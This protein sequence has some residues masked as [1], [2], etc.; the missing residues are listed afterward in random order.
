VGPQLYYPT[1]TNAALGLLP[2]GSGPSAKFVVEGDVI[3]PAFR[4]AEH[5][6]NDS[7]FPGESFRT[8]RR[9]IKKGSSMIASDDMGFFAAR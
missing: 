4:Y 6:V 8:C 3:E 5:C 7:R 2:A 9:M 1:A